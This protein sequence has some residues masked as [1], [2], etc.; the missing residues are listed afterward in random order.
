MLPNSALYR[1]RSAL[2]LALVALTLASCGLPW[3]QSSARISA[4]PDAKQVLRLTLDTANNTTGLAL[5]DP[6]HSSGES[7]DQ[8]ALTLVY[9]GLMTYDASLRPVP[10]LADHVT[11]SP[12]GL[13]YTFHIRNGAR[14]SDGSPITSSDAAFSI[15]RLILGH[16][17]SGGWF[18]SALSGFEAATSGW[19]TGSQV[20]LHDDQVARQLGSGPLARAKPSSWLPFDYTWISSQDPSILH[21]LHQ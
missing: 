9:S 21:M 2:L 18:F 6:A 5:L 17:P 11:V 19:A 14:F 7:S 4:L 10:A 8:Q 16:Q 20:A 3:G 13:R 12:D 1:V 15:A